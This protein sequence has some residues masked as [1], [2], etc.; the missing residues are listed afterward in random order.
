MI[1]SAPW[2]FYRVLFSGATNLL[3]FGRL[4]YST[5]ITSYETLQVALARI[6]KAASTNRD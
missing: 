4:G 6:F 2:M 5:A 1:N 3:A